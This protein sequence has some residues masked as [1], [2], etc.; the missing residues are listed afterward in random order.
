MAAHG[1]DDTVIEIETKLADAVGP[2]R[3][4]E[5]SLGQSLSVDSLTELGLTVGPEP[6]QADHTSVEAGEEIP[7]YV[8]S[9]DWAHERYSLNLLEEL[10]D[11]LSSAG[12]VAL[13][14]GPGARCLELGAGAGSVARWLCTQVGSTG[15]V[16]ATDLDTRWLD[17]LD[18]PNLTVLRHNLL[19]DDLP[20]DSFDFIHARAVLE[21]I[22]D[23][24]TALER[25]CNWL[26]PGGWLFLENIALFPADSSQHS[27]FR[28]A[29]Q[30]FAALMSRTGTDYTW[31]RTFPQPL[32]KCGLQNI[33][34]TV[35]L[36]VLHGGSRFGEWIG[37]SIA[38]Q[39]P[40][41]IDAGLLSEDELAE[42]QALLA[43]PSYWD[44]GPAIVG[45]WGQ[46]P[47]RDATATTAQF[48][49]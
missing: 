41:L 19:V 5:A 38:S 24:D 3:P 48:G 14:V 18:K 20:A 49:V 17:E 34:A 40:R 47:T 8:L 4:R 2:I 28:R 11:P 21:H 46:K 43:D 26:T 1:H 37:L 22:A 27:P 9:P 33:D 12:L 16:T 31:A 36:R 23:R 6:T 7:R 35:D 30:A 15:T 29:M 32:D 44:F 13:G 39:G 10:F 42:A 45:C 25:I